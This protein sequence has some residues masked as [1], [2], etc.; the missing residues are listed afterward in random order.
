M[1][2]HCSGGMSDD[3]HADAMFGEQRVEL[4]PASNGI[5]GTGYGRYEDFPGHIEFEVEVSDLSDGDYHLYVG[6]HERG[7]F[8]VSQGYGELEFASPAEDGKLLL[9]FDPREQQIEVHDASGAVLSSFD[10]VIDADNHHH[11]G[12]HGNDDEH[13]FDC[14]YG[15]GHGHGMGH[16]MGSGMGS[17]MGPG[18]GGMHYC[19]DDGDFIDIRAD[20]RETGSLPGA[21]GQAE[22]DMNSQRVQF[23]VQ[24]ENVPAGLYTLHVAGRDVGV[25][26]AFQMHFGVY[27]H[28]S[29]RDP[30]AYGMHHLDFEPRG[31]L[32]QVRKDDSVILEVEF[33]TE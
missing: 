6:G 7:A 13:N 1:N 22:W 10:D 26:D 2:T 30:V 23:S 21:R 14:Q 32:I 12:Y 8:A 11:G 31:E 24:I 28:I 4:A 20:L 33:P 19:V 3:M 18:M 27:G 25:I 16:G 9:N 5:T 17:G 15:S 29:F